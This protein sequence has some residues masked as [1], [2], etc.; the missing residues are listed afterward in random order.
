MDAKV[1]RHCRTALF[2][3][4]ALLVVLVA[5]AATPSS[6]DAACKRGDFCLWQNANRG[7]GLYF[8]R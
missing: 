5:Y 7:G 2:S 6:A 8:S 4:A 1:L 3:T